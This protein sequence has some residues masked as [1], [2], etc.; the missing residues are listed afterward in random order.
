MVATVAFGMGI[1]KSNVR[2]V[3]HYNL[4]ESLERYYQ[5]MGRAGRDGLPADCLLLYQ[6][7]RP[8]PSP[9]HRGGR[10]AREAGTPGAPP[11]HAAL[12]PGWELPAAAAHLLRRTAGRR[13][14]RNVRHLPAHGAGGRETDV[15]DAARQFLTRVQQTRQMFGV[16]HII[17]AWPVSQASA[18]MT[19]CLFMAGAA[20]LAAVPWWRLAQEL[21]GQGLLV[22]DMEYGGLRLGPRGAENGPR[23]VVRCWWPRN[24]WRP[25]CG[26][27]PAVVAKR[28]TMPASSA[29][30]RDLCGSWQ[31]R[32]PGAGLH[33]LLRPDAARDGDRL[34][35]L[36]PAAAG[37]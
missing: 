31:T 35:K 7:R 30:W 27:W 6:L 32:Q 11:G 36:C 17:N 12:C 4:P 25:P 18:S 14:T 19:A 16:M 21:I 34:P 37:G 5:E 23:G 20:T 3:V 10:R 1:N 26:A 9:L 22:Q 24:R 28:L 13:G 29:N 2:F 33:R 15:T 8:S